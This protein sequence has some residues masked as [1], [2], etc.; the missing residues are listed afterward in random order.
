[1]NHT[2]KK[3]INLDGVI[4][5]G[6]SINEAKHLIFLNDKEINLQHSLKF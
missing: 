3:K 1:M 6:I 5:N 2:Q 4:K